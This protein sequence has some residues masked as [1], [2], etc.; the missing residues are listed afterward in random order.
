M[1]SGSRVT[2]HHCGLLLPQAPLCVEFSF[3]QLWMHTQGVRKHAAKL[4][5]SARRLEGVMRLQQNVLARRV[6]EDAAGGARLH[7]QESL[8]DLETSE[9]QAESAALARVPEVSRLLQRWWEVVCAEAACF[10]EPSSRGLSRRAYFRLH[11]LLSRALMPP[12]SEDR[13]YRAA[14]DDWLGQLAASGAA[15][16]AQLTQLNAA[17]HLSQAAFESGVLELARVWSSSTHPGG[18]SR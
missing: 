5:F 18:E 13:A 3:D 8:R 16:A 14:E 15:G 1:E 7:L 12:G 17:T 11:M 6:L 2:L 4:C 10:D 9:E